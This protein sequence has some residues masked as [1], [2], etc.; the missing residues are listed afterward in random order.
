[1]GTPSNW[2]RPVNGNAI[3]LNGNATTLD[4]ALVSEPGFLKF[5]IFRF[6]IIESFRFGNISEEYVGEISRNNNKGVL[7]RPWTKWR[8]LKAISSTVK[9]QFT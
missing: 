3:T 4:W 7:E 8:L 1:M 2:E 5:Q 6:S 9:C